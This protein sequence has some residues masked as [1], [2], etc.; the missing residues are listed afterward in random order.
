MKTL[1][2]IWIFIQI[3]FSSMAFSAVYV[4]QT[5][6]GAADGTNCANARSVAWFNTASN[7]GAGSTQ[8]NSTNTVYLCGTINNDL[9]FMAGGSTGQYITV[10]GSGAKMNAS[11]IAGP[12]IS[13]GK[14][15]NVT[16]VDNFG[17]NLF[18]CTACDNFIF[19][20]TYADNWHGESWVFISDDGQT[21]RPHHITLSN[22]YLR[23]STGDYGDTQIDIFFCA[24]CTNVVIEGNHLEMRIVGAAPYQQAHDDVL[25]TFQ[26]GGSSNGPPSDLT[27]RY[28][29]IVMNT[30]DTVGDRSWCMLENLD[31]TNYIY[32]NL[33]LGLSGADAANGCAI[34]SSQSRAVFNFFNNTMVSKGTASSNQLNLQNSGTVNLRNNIFYAD[35]GQGWTLGMTNINRSYNLWYGVN[36]PACTA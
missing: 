1:M 34:N 22:N 5:A 8:I 26:K 32:G 20:N 33:F 10:D 17:A 15:Q 7:W 9:N 3:S 12:L 14:I 30:T 2:C 24:G 31:G 13:Y 27:I 36:A 6:V 21:Q 16:W 11:F 19:I 28:N 18:S 35:S 25:Q 23:T 4:A 29:E